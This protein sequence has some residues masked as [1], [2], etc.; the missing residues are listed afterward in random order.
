MAGAVPNYRNVYVYGTGNLFTDRWI[1]AP[2]WR[3]NR[4]VATQPTQGIQSWQVQ[5]SLEAERYLPVP[6]LEVITEDTNEVSRSAA[7]ERLLGD[8]ADGV[9][10]LDG[11]GRAYGSILKVRLTW[12][13]GASRRRAIDIDLGASVD[14]VVPPC[15]WVHA[16]LLIPD[17]DSNRPVPSSDLRD[18]GF[19]ASVT[20]WGAC[21]GYS[22]NSRLNSVRYTDHVYLNQEAVFDRVDI[23]RK[24][25]TMRATAVSNMAL[26]SVSAIWS[27]LPPTR[28]V[29]LG[30]FT[31]GAWTPTPPGSNQLSIHDIPGATNSFR[32]ILPNSQDA[33]I[34]SL[35]QELTF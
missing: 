13:D 22:G 25:S 9:T 29:S 18:I 1:P 3:T 5:I 19:V 31:L 4:L 6:D 16:D 14:V 30:G 11:L 8:T 33:A 24:R 23:A 2:L 28:V 17:P 7:I 32:Y 26:G 15:H 34:F 21:L 35:T 20:G 27:P 10:Q 12:L